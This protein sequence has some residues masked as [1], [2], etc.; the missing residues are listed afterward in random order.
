MKLVEFFP[1][2]DMEAAN[3]DEFNRDLSSEYER[4]RDFLILHYHATERDDSAFWNYCRTM[5]IPQ[6][7]AYKMNLFRAQ[8]HVERYKRGMF[9]EPSWVAVYM[10]QGIFPKTYHPLVN[11][12]EPAQLQQQ[13]AR[14]AREHNATS[15][16]MVQAALA[17]LLSKVSA[18]SVF[19]TECGSGCGCCH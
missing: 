12:Q 15:F 13:V 8:G 7:L 3:S 19:R 4:I 10:G 14:V 17:V 18:S 9:L 2:A 16:M 5:E 6:S 1:Y 11:A